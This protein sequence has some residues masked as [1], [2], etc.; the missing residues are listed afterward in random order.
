V[1]G[2]ADRQR[3]A[4]SEFRLP[5]GRHGIPREEVAANQ[6]WRLLGAVSEVLA[7]SGHVQTTS[8]RVSKKAGVSPATFYQH[9]ENVGECLLMAYEGAAECVS[10][11]VSEACGEEG[12][13]WPS[14]V[15]VAVA[16]T[17]HLLAVEPAMAHLLGPEAPA[18]EPSIATAR[19]ATIERLA[20]LLAGGRDLRPEGAGELPA[21]TERHLIAGAMAICSERVA[22]G[23]V[24]RLP[25]LG[26]EIAAML[27]A[28][29]VS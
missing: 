29:Y 17:L 6:R 1:L 16:S 13:E 25:E 12:I 28:P 4:F 11:I 9:F 8:T 24:E 2:D 23:D 20:G 3:R 22:A 26:P 14:R 15:G 27:T 18:G 7:E 10:E 19:E 21:G 5:P